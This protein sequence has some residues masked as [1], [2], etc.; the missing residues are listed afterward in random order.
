M[1]VTKDTRLVIYGAG[2][3]AEKFLCLYH[4]KYSISF[5]IDRNAS[6]KFHGIPVY[7]LDEA[8][9]Y[10]NNELIVVMA[11]NERIE[12]EIVTQLDEKG[13][14]EYENYIS[15]RK[16]NKKLAI[17]YGNCH[18]SVLEEFFQNVPEFIDEYY[19]DRYYVGNRDKS[20]R[21]PLDGE[22][23][24]CELL[25]TQDIRE[26]NSFEIM[27]FDHCFLDSNMIDFLCSSEM[28]KS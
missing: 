13:F 10:L 4:N 12:N 14:F 27:V 7:T 5:F 11:K 20:K 17:L 22:F 6:R 21:E 9:S 24:R 16:F 25:I 15:L 18:F 2:L 8:V 28:C 19:I 1:I 23:H 3:T 26:Q